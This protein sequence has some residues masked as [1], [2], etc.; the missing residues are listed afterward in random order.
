MEHSMTNLPLGANYCVSLHRK[1]LTISGRI[2][3]EDVWVTEMFG[4]VKHECK[5]RYSHYLHN[6][7]SKVTTPQDAHRRLV[8]Q[9]YLG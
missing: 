8:L 4:Y 5:A 3:T 6:L 7:I 1:S 9:V 2:G